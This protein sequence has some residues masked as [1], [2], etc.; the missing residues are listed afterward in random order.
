MMLLISRY[1][2]LDLILAALAQEG[3]HRFAHGRR[4][5]VAQSGGLLDEA[6]A[7]QRSQRLFGV[8][9][10]DDIQVRPDDRHQSP[11]PEYARED[12]PRN[13]RPCSCARS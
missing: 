13:R 1:S 10:I 9:E 11:L 6:L 3:G 7:D 2:R 5:P 4:P 8:T 12:R